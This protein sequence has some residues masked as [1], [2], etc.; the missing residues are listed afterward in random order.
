MFFVG[1]KQLGKWF[2]WLA[3]GSF[4][5]VGAVSMLIGEKWSTALLRAV[6]AFAVIIILGQVIIYIWKMIPSKQSSKGSEKK[7]RLDVFIGDDETLKEVAATSLLKQTVAGQINL[8]TETGM[9]DP[10]TQA[11]VIKKMGWGE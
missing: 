8:D 6:V 3:A 1:K 4:V 2:M 7:S 11:E 9:P 5:F 10:Q